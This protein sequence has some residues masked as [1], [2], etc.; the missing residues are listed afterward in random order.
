MGVR[1]V[2]ERTGLKASAVWRRFCEGRNKHLFQ[3]SRVQ[4]IT[5]SKKKCKI[6]LTELE[7]W[8]ARMNRCGPLGQEL[9]Q[10]ED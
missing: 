10:S 9:Q 2:L 1:E 6:T 3:R 5:V 7:G 8:I 4:K